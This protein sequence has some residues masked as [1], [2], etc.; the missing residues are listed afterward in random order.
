MK[1]VKKIHESSAAFSKHD[2]RNKN[3]VNKFMISAKY[4]KC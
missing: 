3:L 2:L 1:L 4:R